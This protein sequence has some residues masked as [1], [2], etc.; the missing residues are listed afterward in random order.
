[1]V[2]ANCKFTVIVIAATAALISGGHLAHALASPGAASNPA[3][4]LGLPPG[5]PGFAQ[6]QAKE[7]AELRQ[8]GFLHVCAASLERYQIAMTSIARASEKLAFAPVDLRATPFSRFKALGASA[9]AVN[10]VYSRLYRSFRLPDGHTLTLFEHDMS[11]DGS[12]MRRDP[13]L[14]TERVN[15]LPARLVALQAGPDQAVSSL[16]WREGRRSYDLWV[17]ANVARTPLRAQLL[18]LAASLPRSVPAC[19]KEVPPAAFALGPDG[20]PKADA[21]PP[22]LTGAQAAELL[23]PSARPCK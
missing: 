2:H 23:H 7:A 6:A 8:N 19:P 15:G 4:A 1:M 20:F 22:V 18:A 10:A 5:H 13:A 16:S 3:C 11:A 14:E 9:E 17:D 12:S 21:M